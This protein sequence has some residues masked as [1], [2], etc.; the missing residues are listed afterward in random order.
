MSGFEGP[1]VLRPTI[2]TSQRVASALLHGL[3]LALVV[4]AYAPVWQTML[5]LLVMGVLAL[6]LQRLL[7]AAPARYVTAVILDAED[8]WQ[9][10]T[11]DG[12]THAV[13]LAP[14]VFCTPW[15][16]TLSLRRADGR[17]Q[18][19]VLTS[20]AVDAQAHRRLRVRLRRV[21]GRHGEGG[22][23]AEDAQPR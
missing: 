10:L 13:S 18:H 22:A 21:L 17:L 11:A 15:L 23:A 20:N 9:L 16:I 4:A 3:C 19:L 14:R 6:D 8:R 5:L 2:T 1:L 7:Q 12:A